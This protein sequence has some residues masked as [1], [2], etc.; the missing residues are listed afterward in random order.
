[1]C[2]WIVVLFFLITSAQA[3]T[4]VD[5]RTQSKNVDFSTALATLPSRTAA[6]DPASCRDGESYWNTT[7]HKRRD[8]AAGT[9]VDAVAYG[10]SGSGAP[11]AVCNSTN[12][13]AFYSDT[14]GKNAWWCDGSAWQRILSTNNTGPY[15]LTGQSGTLPATPA[16]GSVTEYFD[17]AARLPQSIDE[18][19]NKATMV[20][21]NPCPGQV[22]QSVGA[23]GSITCGS[24]GGA[25]PSW[26][27]INPDIWD[28]FCGS[29]K[30]PSGAYNL[31]GSLRWFV[32]N[33]SGTA[34]GVL[35]R[36]AVTQGWPCAVTIHSGSSVGQQ[37]T[38]LSEPGAYPFQWADLWDFKLR[39][40]PVGVD[41]NVAIRF[42]VGLDEPR[43]F[44]ANGCYFESG[45]TNWFRICRSGGSTL[46]STDTGIAVNTAGFDSLRLRRID[47]NT[48]GFTIAGNAEQTIAAPNLPSFAGVNLVLA[49]STNTASDRTVDIARFEG[50]LQ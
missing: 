32:Q 25:L 12:P 26:L 42:G 31:L 24:G 38:A 16:V 44:Y 13:G 36:Q 7:S 27:T 29:L 10:S 46:Q 34:Q 43:N 18:N 49:I 33:V 35:T 17:A 6:S 41:S 39:L 20:R 3:Q 47:G 28:Q 50:K 5:L 22:V 14:G 9:W 30:D 19:G 4:Q 48:L 15:T 1:M 45:A 23:N 40:K 11:T 21:P 8:C 2:I 37:G